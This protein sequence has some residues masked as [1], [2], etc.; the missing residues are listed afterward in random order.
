MKPHEM[1]LS[2]RYRWTLVV[3]TDAGSSSRSCRQNNTVSDTVLEGS[4]RRRSARCAAGFAV[5]GFDYCTVR[6]DHVRPVPVS[7]SRRKKFGCILREY[8]KPPK[9]GK[10]PLSVAQNRACVTPLRRY[11]FR[12]DASESSISFCFFFAGSV[13]KCD[14]GFC[15]SFAQRIESTIPFQR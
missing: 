2:Y 8:E 14:I 10:N 11:F 6:L 4:A 13:S 7:V 1:C 9:N 15:L 3:S 12:Y 5:G